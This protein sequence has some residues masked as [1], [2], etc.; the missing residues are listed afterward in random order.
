MTT[1]T[2]TLA[3]FIERYRSELTRMI[4]T[5]V[6]NLGALDDDDIEQWI[7][8]DEGLYQWALSEGVEDL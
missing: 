6:P 5:S 3:K 1:P 8:N 7:A 2:R 4:R